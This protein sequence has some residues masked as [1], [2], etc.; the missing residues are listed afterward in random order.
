[1]VAVKVRVRVRVSPIKKKP[2][3]G[4]GLLGIPFNAE[5]ALT[6]TP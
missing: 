1:M 4:K 5:R 2:L 3:H 6:L